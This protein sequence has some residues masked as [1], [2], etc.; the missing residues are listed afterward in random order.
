MDRILTVIHGVCVCVDLQNQHERQENSQL[1]AE[2]EKL[3]AEN[4]RYKEALS[5]ASCPNCG[6][7]AAFGEMSFDEHHLRVENARLREEIDRIS[8]IAAKYVGKPMVSFPVLSSPLAGARPSPLDIDSGGVLGG[9]ATYGGAADIFGGGGG[10]AACGA[11][12]DCDKPMIVELAVTAMEELVRM[13]Q[14]DEPLWNAPA[15]GHDG[16]AE[17][18]NE[19]E[20]ARM[21]VPA[22]G[23]GLKKQ[24]GFKS[25]ASRDSSVVIMTHASLVEIL[26]DVVCVRA[27]DP[28]CA[29]STTFLVIKIV[30]I[31]LKL[32]ILIQLASPCICAESVCDGVLEHRVESCDAGGAVHRRGWELQWRIASGACSETCMRCIGSFFMPSLLLVLLK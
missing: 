2:N 25:E 12:R 29:K 20:Y 6:G 26:M 15:G 4:M 23:L 17:T 18:L 21:F 28:P 13:A 32:W 8:A 1:R 19:E 7:P 31:Y 9:A 14:L 10:V 16:S 3:R 22:G 27:C 24:Y 11:A 30:R 5:S